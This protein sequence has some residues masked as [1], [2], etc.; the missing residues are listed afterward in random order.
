MLG[1]MLGRFAGAMLLAAVVAS[2]QVASASV[3]G[4][5]VDMTG[6]QI[7]GALV[8]IESPMPMAGAATDATGHF[9]ID[10]I[11]PGTYTLRMQAGGFVSRELEVQIDDAK[12]SALGLVT[13]DVK[14]PPSCID[15]LKKSDILQTMLPS[16]SSSRVSGSARGEIDGA[17]K[18]FNVSLLGAGTTRV[19]ANSTTDENG[20]FQFV[21]VAP[22]TYDLEVSSQKIRNLRVRKGHE[23]VVHLVWTQPQVCL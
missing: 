21:Y 20:Q 18:D 7:P 10:G 12:E 3:A 8:T 15:K 11:P 5:V 2:A 9:V 1:A 23:L 4:T 6:S 16:G 17:L 19:I 13:L 22:G 14:A